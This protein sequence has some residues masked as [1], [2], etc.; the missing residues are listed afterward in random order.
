[1]NYEEYSPS[2]RIILRNDYRRFSYTI[3]PRSMRHRDQIQEV[4]GKVETYF[5]SRD[6]P[7]QRTI[8]ETLNSGR[9]YVIVFERIDEAE[10]F[11]LAFAEH[12]RTEGYKF[13]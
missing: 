5:A 12:I 6:I 11:C 4:Q 9:Y 3:T 13:A 1:M 7:A 10:M 2:G 8:E